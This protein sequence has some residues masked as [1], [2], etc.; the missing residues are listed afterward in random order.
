MDMKRMLVVGPVIYASRQLDFENNPDYVFYLRIA[1]GLVLLT[2]FCVWLY[3]YL[4]AQKSEDKKV[5]KVPED[6]SPFSSEAPK[7]NEMTVP[8]YDVSQVKKCL[9]Q[10]VMLG[11]IISF[12]HIQYAAVTPLVVQLVLRPLT[13]FDHGIF[14]AYILG[15]HVARPFPPP[16]SPFDGLKDMQQQLA[17][18][19]GEEAP[20]KKK[21]RKPTESDK[22]KKREQLANKEKTD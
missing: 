9:T 5:I 10:L 11:G 20:K 22:A 13:M 15:Q 21:S 6:A 1:F 18:A 14:K 16:K 19:S 3:C 12:I 17:E 7:M 4:T 2:E 8:E